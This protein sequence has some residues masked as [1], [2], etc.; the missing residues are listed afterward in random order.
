MAKSTILERTTAYLRSADGTLKA[1]VPMN[2]QPEQSRD[3]IAEA[4]KYADQSYKPRAS[5]LANDA[6]R[7]CAGAI[8]PI[9]FAK[10][11]AQW[12]DAI[13]T[14]RGDPNPQSAIGVL[15]TFVRVDNG[16]GR[17]FWKAA[18]PYSFVNTLARKVARGEEFL[19]L[20]DFDQVVRKGGTLA[21]WA[22]KAACL[23]RIQVDKGLI[24]RDTFDMEVYSM[25][26]DSFRTFSSR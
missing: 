9:F 11:V 20:I 14:N 26:S 17:T 3:S 12:E 18:T 13:H 25:L 5:I 22:Y 21:E 7:S 16:D 1:E 15:G 4:N 19:E 6:L 10:L 23:V 8:G 2:T 24:P